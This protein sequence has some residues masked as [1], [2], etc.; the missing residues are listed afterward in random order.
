MP[1]IDHLLRALEGTALAVTI[2]GETGWGWLFPQIETV[3]VLALAT[4][5]GS[6][7][8]VDLRLLGFGARRS[9]VSAVSAEW[10]PLT[11]TAYGVAACAGTLLFISKAH[12]YFH[13]PQFEFKFL[14]MLLAGANMLVFHL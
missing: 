12:T 6:I 14:C 9:A 13:N 2:R 1:T 3:H 7:A 8:M 11:W 5:F 10:L 4:V